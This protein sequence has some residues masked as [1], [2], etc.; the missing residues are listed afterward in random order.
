MRHGTISSRFVRAL[1]TFSSQCVRA[2]GTFSSQFTGSKAMLLTA[3]K[4]FEI[5]FATL[6]KASFRNN[7][8]QNN[9]MYVI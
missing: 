2:L 9:T 1:G 8:I 3:Y 7:V 4:L 5:D 6:Y